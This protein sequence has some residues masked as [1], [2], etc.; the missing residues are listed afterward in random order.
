MSTSGTDYLRANFASLE[1]ES[2]PLGDETARFI[3]ANGRF[4]RVNDIFEHLICND[5]FRPEAYTTDLS[6]EVRH[7]LSASAKLPDWMRPEQIDLGE[8]V[9]SHYGPECMTALLFKSLPAGYAHWHVAETLA[10]TGRMRIEAKENLRLTRR[11]LETL[12]FV[13]YVMEEGGLTD[14]TKRGV[15]AIQKVRLIHA[16]I[17]VFICEDSS[18]EPDWPR[19]LNQVELVMTMLTFSL[20]V[21][22]GAE[23]MGVVL[24]EEEQEGVLHLWK[25][26][27]SMLGT[28]DELLPRDIADARAMWALIDA[29]DRRA[30]E[31]GVE[32][33]QALI[34]YGKTIMPRRFMAFVPAML[35][36]F[37]SGRDRAH[38]LGVKK[39]FNLL[40][41]LGLLAVR[42]GVVL[43]SSAARRWP[44]FAVALRKFHVALLKGLLAHWNADYWHVRKDIN[45]F[46]PPALH[47]DWQ[48]PMIELRPAST[49]SRD[50]A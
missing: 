39:R 16:T 34:Y 40:Q 37:Y 45:F 8:R 41:W 46:I 49:R 29:H 15:V 14:P 10:I 12:Q 21:M 31:A 4:K 1:Q 26:V 23:Q 5:D 25:V 35:I 20:L 18:W 50:D 33:T 27:A 9:Y 24:T 30:T 47:D 43:V 38:A 6:R 3:A 2:D 42:L 28:R 13:L 44:W 48:V 19:P 7:Y 32:L 11:I 36:V 22:D 17:R